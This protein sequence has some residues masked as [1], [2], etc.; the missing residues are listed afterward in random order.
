MDTLPERIRSLSEKKYFAYIAVVFF[1][2]VTALIFALLAQQSTYQN[3]DSL[4]SNIKQNETS[5]GFQQ[6]SPTKRAPES[7][8]Q[9][10]IS[11]ISG[12]T[13]SKT[14]T[15]N[16]QN[17]IPGNTQPVQQIERNNSGTTVP[18]NNQ[19]QIIDTINKEVQPLP[20]VRIGD[21]IL[22]TELP[23]QPTS[24]KIYKLK[25]TYS[26]TDIAQ[27][28]KS[29]GFIPL[30]S[31]TLVVEKNSEGLT[32]LFDL[33]NK[34][35]L[36]VN[37]QTGTILFTAQN[38]IP[39]L[40]QG[41]VRQNALALARSLGYSQSCL[42]A[43][44]TY[45]KNSSP[46]TS[47]VDIHC[48]WDSTGA[49]IINYFGILNTPTNQRLTDVSLGQLPSIE[50][51][52]IRDDSTGEST[53]RPNDFNTITVQQDTITGN[54]M[55]FSSNI[56]P[57]L[58][59][60]D[61]PQ[62]SIISPQNAFDNIKVNK[63]Q[64]AFAA[65]LGTG[66]TD[67]RNVYI[68]N[69][70]QSNSVQTTDF[71]Y[72]YP[73]IPGI[74]QEYMCPVWLTRSQGQLE[75]GY[76][77]QF[78]ESAQAIN[79]V[80][81]EKPA[82]LGATIAQST[83][84][85]AAPTVIDPISKGSTLQY[86]QFTFEGEPP[87]ESSC[88]IS[89][90]FTNAMKISPGVFIAWIDRNTREAKDKRG[91]GGYIKGNLIQ[92][93]W[94]IVTTS[95]QQAA[96]ALGSGDSIPLELKNQYLEFRKSRAVKC[97]IGT[98]SD[99]PIPGEL[100][101][102]IVACKYLTTGSPSLYIHSDTPQSVRVAITPIGGIIF[103]QPPLNISQGWK[104]TTTDKEADRLY[105]EYNKQEIQE[106]IKHTIFVRTGYSVAKSELLS[107]FTDSIATRLG[108]SSSQSNDLVAEVRREIDSIHT[109]FVNVILVPRSIIDALFPISIT[110]TPVIFDRYF[111]IVEE[112]N[113]KVLLPTPALFK[114]KTSHYSALETGTLILGTE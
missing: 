13:T 112:S 25:T 33:K 106:A 100:A 1:A 32:Q 101:G 91:M 92:R 50:D 30:Q 59:E 55:A 84:P 8:I 72:V 65:P 90:Q 99:C 45:T 6:T 114:Q 5:S 27:I 54:I 81:C 47:Y 67:L 97:E 41:D 40:S 82:V 7:A 76:D 18:S 12:R 60:I 94:W 21:H 11:V 64:F 14:V 3:V 110:P 34:L 83:L 24:A 36:A 103:A 46:H 43:T 70:A 31:D 107:L 48:D 42:K 113:K 79:D 17:T 86:K 22:Q 19:K 52:N 73:V 26:D 56:L 4:R 62:S 87:S 57:V 75:S 89:E 77:G 28:S 16:N 10:I 78:I 9:K 61:I 15:E 105:W 23:P 88:P 93:E 63:T 69:T 96:S 104:I 38:G 98:R 20:K 37:N 68:Q 49:P 85:I 102:N 66:F 74:K 29:L 109:P 2:F 35:Y 51:T 53:R 58:A 71:M 111:F 95:S 44:S 39:S 80:R 108:L